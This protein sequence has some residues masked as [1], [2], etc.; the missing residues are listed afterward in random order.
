MG[1][2]FQSVQHGCLDGSNRRCSTLSLSANPASSSNFGDQVVLTASLSP[3]AP[4]GVSSNGEVITFYNGTTSVGTGTLTN[5]VATLTLNSLPIGTDSLTAVYPGDA[6]LGIST[7]GAVAFT[8]SNNPLTFT[9]SGG[10]TTTTVA[11]NGTA[12]YVFLVTP[13]SSGTFGANVTFAVTGGPTGATATF[14]PA[15]ITAGSGPTSVTLTVTMGT[16]SGVQRNVGA[17]AR[18]LS[19]LALGLV[20]LPFAGRLRRGGK[21]WGSLV[22]LLL[23]LGGMGA[24]L[25][26]CGGSSSPATTPTPT[27]AAKTYTMT[28]TATSGSVSQS[29]NL[30]LIVN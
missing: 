14:N 4:E 22:C 8:V 21:R 18:R 3:F 7:S 10:T 9:L 19:P 16:Q 25:V 6:N 27:P 26:G 13:G 29:S 28:V 23:L 24:G 30:T 12:T 17:I 11:S 15:S 1:R 2:V 20:L 5:G